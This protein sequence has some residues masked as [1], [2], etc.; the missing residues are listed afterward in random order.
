MLV[1]LPMLE[2]VN[3]LDLVDHGSSND[4]TSMRKSYQTGLKNNGFTNAHPNE[5]KKDIFVRW[6]REG[7]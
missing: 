1:S 6:G 7:P 4:W 3:A 2:L 5:L